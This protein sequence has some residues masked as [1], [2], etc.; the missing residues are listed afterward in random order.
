MVGK[1]ST[2]GKL[3]VAAPLLLDAAAALLR[4]DTLGLSSSFPR[5]LS[6]LSYFL[7]MREHQ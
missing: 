2:V 4:L 5:I 7:S 3:R 1:L 6:S